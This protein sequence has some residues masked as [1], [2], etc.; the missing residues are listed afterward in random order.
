MPRYRVLIARPLSEGLRQRYE[1]YPLK[2]LMTALRE[3]LST[4]ADQ[5]R[6]APFPFMLGTLT[7]SFEIPTD[8][9]TYQVSPLYWIDE[10]DAA[11]EIVDIGILP[12][13]GGF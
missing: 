7:Q 8:A 4:E 12:I 3:R 5:G 11:V 9:G 6:Q 2:E 10:G 1:G 13:A